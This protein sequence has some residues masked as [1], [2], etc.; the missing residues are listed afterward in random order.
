MG[1]QEFDVHGR[2]PAGADHLRL[3]FSII[4]VGLVE[5]HLQRGVHPSR[6]Q[7]FYRQ[8][9]LAQSM[10]QPGCHRSGLNPHPRVGAR[11]PHD[12]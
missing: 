8:P 5:P 4:L 7:T 6:V 10:H 1:V 12:A 11:M 2:V 9:S 3:P